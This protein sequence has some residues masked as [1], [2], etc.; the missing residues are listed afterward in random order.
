MLERKYDSAI[1]EVMARCGGGPQIQNALAGQTPDCIIASNGLTIGPRLDAP[2]PF[3]V[4]GSDRE[5][6]AGDEF[7]D[8]R[9]GVKVNATTRE[10][11]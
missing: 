8:P 9:P 7:I 6:E 5:N 11:L 4:T 2:S 3:F 1:T 10:V